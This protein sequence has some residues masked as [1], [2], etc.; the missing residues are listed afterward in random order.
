[1]G[2]GILMSGVRISWDMFDRKLLFARFSSSAAR[3][4]SE[5][6][7]LASR[8]WSSIAWHGASSLFS[9]VGILPVSSFFI[10]SIVTYFPFWLQDL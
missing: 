9:V 5:S 6:L 2:Q 10:A 7:V 8:S 3:S 1:M 4:A